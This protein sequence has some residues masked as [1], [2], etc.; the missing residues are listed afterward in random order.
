VAGDDPGS[1]GPRVRVGTVRVSIGVAHFV[2]R[3]FDEAAPKLR[4]AIQEDPNF[5]TPYRFLAACYA[6]WAGSTTPER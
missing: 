1:L 4:L 6:N 3:R 2:A 5:P